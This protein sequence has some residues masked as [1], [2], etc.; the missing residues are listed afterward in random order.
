MTTPHTYESEHACKVCGWHLVDDDGNC[1]WC[2]AKNP[3][4]RRA[5]KR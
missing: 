1:I 2:G 5:D 3:K 4:G